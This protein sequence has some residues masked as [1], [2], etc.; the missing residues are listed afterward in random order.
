MYRGFE[1]NSDLIAGHSLTIAWY[2]GRADH[3][4]QVP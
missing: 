4:A 1:C 2:D 3:T